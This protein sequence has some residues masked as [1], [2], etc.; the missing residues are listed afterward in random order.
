LIKYFREEIII[1]EKDKITLTIITIEIKNSQSLT[2]LIR[3]IV[4]EE[5]E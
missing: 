3:I 1:K 5:E 2:N 4:E